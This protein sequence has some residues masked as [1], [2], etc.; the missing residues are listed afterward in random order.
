MPDFALDQF[1]IDA[2]E[3]IDRDASVLVAAPTG[4]GKT[5]VADHAVDRAIAQGTRAFYPTPIKAL[6]NQKYQDLVARLGAE[7]VGL[8]TGDNAINGDAPVVV[9][10]TEVLRNMIYASPASLHSLAWVVLDEV[11]YLQDA[12][13]GP[14]WEEVI[15]HLPPHV[16]VVALSATVSNADELAAWIGTVRGEVT[17]VVETR[18]P[19]ELDHLY[20]YDDRETGATMV[21]PTLVDGRP[22]RRGE[23]LDQPKPIRGQRR[24]ARFATPHRPEVV[25]LL[26]Q[27][28]LLPAIVFV[29]SRAGCDDAVDACRRAG[30]RLTTGPE[31]RRIRELVEQRT[32]ALSDADLD[33]LG[34]STWL[35]GLEAGLA[36]HHAGMIPA[37]KEAVE[38]CFVE[39]LVKVVFATETL[40]LGI[41]MPARSVVIEKLTKF[42]GEHHEF[43]T[44]GQYT[45]LTGRAGRRGLDER[46]TAIVLWSPWVGFGEVAA[47]AASRSFRLTSSFRPTYNMAANLIRRYGPEEA[48]SLLDA[49]FA[50]FQADAAV[51]RLDVRLRT[52]RQRVTELAEQATCERG[53]VR[54]HR[55]EL[56][57]VE[58]TRLEAARSRQRAIDEALRRLS[59]GDVVSLSGA[60][61][62]AVLSVSERRAGSVRLRTID[63]DGTVDS[64]G[65]AQVDA[66]PDLLSRISLP[67][68]FAPRQE[69]F[70]RQV[71]ARL[72]EEIDGA[73]L[74]VATAT[75]PPVPSPGGGGVADCPDVEV[76]LRALRALGRAER[77]VASLERRVGAHTDTLARHLDRVLAVLRDRHMVVDWSLT[78]AGE[79]L[80]RLYHESD[81][82]V[83]E[84]LER[85]VFD[86]L[87]P[88]TLAGLL[89]AV[90]YEHRSA[91][92]PP[93][94]W[95][96]SPEAAR[97]YR[98]L[99]RL[100]KALRRDE[101]A[102]EL[103]ETRAPDPTFVATAY[104]WAAGDELA[105]VL[106]D[107][108][109]SGGDFVRT[110]KQLI[111][112][113][114]QLAQAAPDPA[115]A[116]AARAAAD[117][118]RR[119]VVA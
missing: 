72:R 114:G 8:L 19:V 68:P 59:P 54:A 95:F 78:P 119:G 94:P 20:A 62:V 24:R 39:G 22:N 79:R 21:L 4:A 101:R 81:L 30:F 27:R 76:H 113:A 6:S 106:E 2:A 14:V 40:A 118:M 102:H 67:H 52:A 23:K 37:F 43:L 97:R 77:E 45:Q 29:F 107:E 36:S 41:N 18:R 35:D 26:R 34:Y 31:R 65:A 58:R 61:P 32:A 111:D 50:Q 88:P 73:S 15:I 75:A 44:P 100:A 66:V 53:D 5:V 117:A 86:D 90:I 17:T 98:Q 84:A 87:D 51:V 57:R 60:A 38:A 3:A 116:A 104:A 80:V 70:Q 85:G 16:R 74:P 42:T 28:E 103:P 69:A 109:L 1:Q 82:L 9:M 89:S 33:A 93:A 115:T 96:P 92:P 64:V 99:E 56:E 63:A 55:A 71:A 12:Y 49:S 105:E 108:L 112:L 10:T 46:G 25:D 48:R 11:H 91:E 83:A 7:R 13:R 47:L 110:I